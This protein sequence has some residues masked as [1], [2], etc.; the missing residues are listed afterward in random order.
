MRS[1]EGRRKKGNKKR[2]SAIISSALTENG[3]VP[4]SVSLSPCRIPSR[5]FVFPVHPVMSKRS[6]LPVFPETGAE[7]FEKISQERHIIP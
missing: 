3:K 4:S 2:L 1:Q 6:L 5:V 7:E